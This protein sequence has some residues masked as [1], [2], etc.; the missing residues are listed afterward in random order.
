MP[1]RAT[2]L[3]V[4][5]GL[6]LLWTSNALATFRGTNG[7][8]AFTTPRGIASPGTLIESINVGAEDL[9]VPDRAD[10]RMTPVDL[11]GDAFDPSWSADGR[12]LAFVSTRAGQQQIYTVQLDFGRHLLAPC[13]IEA[14]RLTN[15]PSDNYDPSWSLD[16]H[17]LAFT[18]TRSGTPQIYRMT[19]TGTRITRLTHDTSADEQP[20]WSQ[21]GMLAFTGNET[22]VPQIYAMSSTGANVRQITSMSA[23]AKDPSWSPDGKTL[24]FVGGTTGSDQIFVVTIPGGAPVPLTQ[25]EP[26]NTAPQWSPDGLKLLITHRG[27]GTGTSELEELDASSGKLLLAQIASGEDGSWAPLPLLPRKR[28][29][30]PRHTGPGPPPSPPPS[31]AACATPSPPGSTPRPESTSPPRSTSPAGSSSPPVAVRKPPPPVVP[32]ASAIAVAVAGKVTVT[33]GRLASAE[34]QTEQ[35]DTKKA[36]PPTSLGGPPSA[37]ASTVPP[38]S[39]LPLSSSPLSNTEEVVPVDSTYQAESGVVSLTVRRVAAADATSHAEVGGGIFIL[40][41]ADPAAVPKIRLVTSARRCHRR[42][43][44]ASRILRAQSYLRGRSR[45]RWSFAAGAGRAS[46]G[47]D[48]I[49]EVVETCSGTLY[50]AITGV[51]IVTD[52]HRRHAIRVTAGHGYLVR[53]HK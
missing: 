41:Q 48:P 27:D 20:T 4:L 1:R 35:Q 26:D 53:S 13:A 17:T 46:V 5:L 16:G 9:A 37:P 52:P 7:A 30:A 40:T 50:R 44:V 45:G 34:P 38:P 31:C 21:T 3:T 6:S 51:L 8:V 2:L 29:V 22:G 18:S 25:F 14:C 32:G 49:W 36:P 43:A 47:G 12:R 11:A 15:S 23:G 42:R 33:P 28:R 10:L 24:A 39:T 19:E